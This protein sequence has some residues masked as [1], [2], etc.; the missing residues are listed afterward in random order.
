VT[1]S[2]LIFAATVTTVLFLGPGSLPAANEPP[3]RLRLA[4]E[5]SLIETGLVGRL[6][7]AWE[8]TSA[9]PLEVMALPAGEAFRRSTQ[10]GIDVLLVDDGAGEARFIHDGRGYHRRVV[11]G[12]WFVIVGPAADP[13]GVAGVPEL[14]PPTA[15]NKSCA[16]CG[17]G[18]KGGEGSIEAFRR[19][20]AGGHPF[21]SG[22]DGSGT[23]RKEDEIRV[24]SGF[25]ERGGWYTVAGKTPG[26]TLA[27]AAARKA[28]ALVDEAL[29]QV[30]EDRLGGLRP[31]FT[32]RDAILFHPFSVIAVNPARVD[33]VN[34]TGALRFVRWLG[35]EEA[36]EIIGTFRDARGRILYL[37]A[38][39]PRPPP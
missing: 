36:A 4:A 2:R 24:S 39:A 14:P 15:G 33:G 18:P 29:F 37:P 38:P 16:A 34:E 1:P 31:L 6:A 27:A 7:Q 10:G 35:G 20:A 21:V 23:S 22:G 32:R 5:P 26:E 25:E 11:F 12:D 8:R 3:T 17:K 13:A 30:L 28:Y 19:I 9:V